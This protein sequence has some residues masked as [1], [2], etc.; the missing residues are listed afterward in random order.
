MWIFTQRLKTSP[1]KVTS[2]L[3]SSC[4]WFKVTSNLNSSCTSRSRRFVS[5]YHDLA[6][7][8]FCKFST[9]RTSHLTFWSEESNLRRPQEIWQQGSSSRWKVHYLELLEN[10]WT[11]KNIYIKVQKEEQ[12]LTNCPINLGKRSPN[13][14]IIYYSNIDNHG[15]ASIMLACYHNMLNCMLTF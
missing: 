9:D 6:L 14:L 10:R 12:I 15:K 7:I 13:T 3:N 8:C 11:W 5:C 1:K 2:N 4:T